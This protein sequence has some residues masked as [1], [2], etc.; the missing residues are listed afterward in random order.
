MERSLLALAQVIQLDLEIL[1]LNI[2]KKFLDFIVAEDTDIELSGNFIGQGEGDLVIVYSSGRYRMA[3]RG[4]L[5]GVM[6]YGDANAV[7]LERISRFGFLP[8]CP[9]TLAVTPSRTITD[10]SIFEIS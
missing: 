3:G 2:Y 1:H 10:L 8:V 5:A 6:P 7:V 9:R 4:S